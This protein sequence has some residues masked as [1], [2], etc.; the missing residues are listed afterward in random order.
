MLGSSAA[1][2]RVYPWLTAFPRSPYRRGTPAWA[3]QVPAER[4]N[5]PKFEPFWA[6]GGLLSG[7]GAVDVSA[8][9]PLIQ[10]S[11]E[12]G[13]AIATTAIDANTQKE[14]AR[15]AAKKK[16]RRVA[17]PVFQP[18]PIPTPAGGFAVGSLHIFMLLGGLAVA[19]VI[20][21]R[22]SQS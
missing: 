4:K 11:I 13:G 1:G 19:G 17:T 14:L 15:Q 8:F 16:G 20:Y 5:L 3:Q 12:A 21:A 10:T 6:R 22:R 2:N 18:A 7:L 9:V